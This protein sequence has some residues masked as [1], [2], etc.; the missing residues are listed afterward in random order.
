VEIGINIMEFSVNGKEAIDKYRSLLE[1]PDII[2]MDHRMPVMNGIDAMVEILRINK[3]VK[4]IF[5]SADATVKE[6]AISMGATAFLNK[7]LN[8]QVLI[9]IIKKESFNEK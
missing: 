1:K 7:P 5:V 6:Q 2:I 8:I 4:I 3:N 9:N